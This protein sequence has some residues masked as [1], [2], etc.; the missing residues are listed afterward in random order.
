[1]SVLDMQGVGVTLGKTEVLVDISMYLAR[2]SLFQ[3]LLHPGQ[4]NPRSFGCLQVRCAMT[5]ARS[6]A[7]IARLIKTHRILLSC[8]SVMP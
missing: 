5:V 4:G 2:A 8:R 3:F 7:M 1:M 6:P